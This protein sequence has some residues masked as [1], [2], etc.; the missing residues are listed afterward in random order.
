[1]KQLSISAAAREIKQTC[2]R[3][4][5]RSRAAASLGAAT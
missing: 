3:A 2:L 5:Q 4:K 1:M